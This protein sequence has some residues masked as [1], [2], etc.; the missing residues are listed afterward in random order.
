[1]YCVPKKMISN[2]HQLFLVGIE[3]FERPVIQAVYRVSGYEVG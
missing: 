2:E 1:M 3:D